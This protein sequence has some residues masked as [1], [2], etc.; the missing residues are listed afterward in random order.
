MIIDAVVLP[1]GAHSIVRQKNKTQKKGLLHRTELSRAVQQ[2]FFIFCNP[3]SYQTDIA[4]VLNYFTAAQ[5]NIRAV[6]LKINY[7][8]CTV[9]VISRS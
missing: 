7:D 1:R 5:V 4:A 2:F 9:G 6:W 3:F 8:E